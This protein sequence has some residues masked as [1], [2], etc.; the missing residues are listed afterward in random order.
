MGSAS[1]VSMGFTI[2]A[3]IISMGRQQHRICTS[4]K[5]RQAIMHERLTRA[6]QHLTSMPGVAVL[7]H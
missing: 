1:A 4:T 2:L 6:W 3:A 5:Q 7:S